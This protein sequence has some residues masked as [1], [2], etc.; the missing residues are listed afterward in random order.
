MPAGRASSNEM[1]GVLHGSAIAIACIAASI[2]SAR[3]ASADD[4]PAPI[5]VDRPIILA[6]LRASF[7][8]GVA[9]ARV[10]HPDGLRA[11]GATSFEAA[12]G[13]PFLMELGVRTGHRWDE[14]ASVAAVDRYARLFDHETAN[15]GENAWSNP[16]IRLRLSAIDFGDVALGIEGRMTLPFADP[17]HLT[18]APGLPVRIRIAH[19]AR[20]DTGL[21][22]PFRFDPDTRYTLSVPAELWFQI[23]NVFFGPMTGV[24]WHRIVVGGA[25]ATSRLDVAAGLGV[26]WTLGPV[27]LKA[28][29]YSLR[30]NDSVGRRSYAVAF[31]LGVTL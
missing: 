25:D 22:M 27:D 28:Q 20:I 30:I 11:A 16:E 19:R 12:F 14:P 24:R 31:G 21:F 9:S 5:W 7:D 8:V 2:A 13:L 3:S 1:R 23:Q 10:P 17:T 26:G 29:T 18:I 6:P 15:A 4:A